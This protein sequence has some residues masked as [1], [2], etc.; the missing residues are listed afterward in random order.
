MFYTNVLLLTTTSRG[1][2]HAHM[3]PGMDDGTTSCLDT[4][5]MDVAWRGGTLLTSRPHEYVM[6]LFSKAGNQSLRAVV[7]PP[8]DAIRAALNLSNVSTT[9]APLLSASTAARAFL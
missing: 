4:C 3:H 1:C 8:N 9:A 2:T 5:A 7:C 6:Q